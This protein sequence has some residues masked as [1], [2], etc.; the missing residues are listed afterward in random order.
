MKKMMKLL[1]VHLNK[2]PVQI[3]NSDDVEKIKDKMTAGKISP[4]FSTSNH[5]GEGIE[6]LRSF[7]GTL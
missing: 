7:I 2:V 5:T 3:K 1:K 4:V 6:L